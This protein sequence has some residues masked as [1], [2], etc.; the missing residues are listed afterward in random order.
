MSIF[1]WIAVVLISMTIVTVLPTP[2]R[3]VSRIA[4]SW[5]VTAVVYLTALAFTGNLA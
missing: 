4:L 3:R 1:V 2:Q 5:S